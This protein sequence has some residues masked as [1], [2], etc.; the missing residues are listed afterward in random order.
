[1]QSHYVVT[2][3]S[4]LAGCPLNTVSSETFLSYHSNTDHHSWWWLIRDHNFQSGDLGPRIDM[5]V[6]QLC[7]RGLGISGTVFGK[8]SRAT[9]LELSSRNKEQ[10]GFFTS[11]LETKHSDWVKL[12]GGNNTCS[13]CL[14][15][16][17]SLCQWSRGALELGW[18]HIFEQSTCTGKVGHPIAESLCINN[19]IFKRVGLSIGRCM[20]KTVQT[21]AD[22]TLYCRLIHVWTATDTDQSTLA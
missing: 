13:L 20:W 10:F 5:R 8:P 6:P 21:I 17:Q 9:H 15:K 16:S 7:S 14:G 1:M 22:T 18:C 4:G 19:I 11:C 3:C 12:K 2:L